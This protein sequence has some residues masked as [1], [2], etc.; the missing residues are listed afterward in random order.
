MIISS[1]YSKNEHVPS[2]YGNVYIIIAELPK[3]CAEV[4]I[5]V[6]VVYDALLKINH[7][8]CFKFYKRQ[9]IV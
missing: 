6:L 4:E 1:M 3:R 8:D 9:H 2:L 7:G 5:G